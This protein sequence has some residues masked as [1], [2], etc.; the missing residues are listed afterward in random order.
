MQ[1]YASNR[2]RDTWRKK[3]IGPET[4]KKEL[5]TFRMIW[6]W[7]V[8]QELIEGRAPVRGIQ[9]PK[10]DE[11]PPFMTLT[12]AERILKQGGFTKQQ[13]KEICGAIFLTRDDIC[14]LLD[15]IRLTAKHSFLYPLFAFVAHTGARRS[16]ILNARLED[17]DL[18]AETVSLRER[19]NRGNSATTYRRV[20][21]TRLLSQAIR[22]WLKTTP[23]ARMSSQIRTR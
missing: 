23:V 12:D 4:V 16:E 14:E 20:D 9:F 15:H 3:R 19:K 18:A 17:F 22:D 7:A 6:N 2:L 11:K 13:E 21:L 5:A 8:N 10:R 1:D